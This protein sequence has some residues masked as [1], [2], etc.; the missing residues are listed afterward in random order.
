MAKPLLPLVQYKV[1]RHPPPFPESIAVVSCHNEHDD[2]RVT[3]LCQY[4]TLR[5]YYTCFMN[6]IPGTCTLAIF[7]TSFLGLVLELESRTVRTW[8]FFFN[9][10]LKKYYWA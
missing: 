5:T 9:K 10:K 4:D 7:H 8:Y 3:I 6:N 1:P 2:S